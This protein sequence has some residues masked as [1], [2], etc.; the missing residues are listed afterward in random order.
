MKPTIL[1]VDDDN[2]VVKFYTR[3]LEEEGF[4]V[5]QTYDPDETLKLIEKEKP[6]LSAIILDIMMPPGET[7]SDEDTQ[8]GLRTGTFLY[9]DL[10]AYYPNVPVVVLTNVTDQET[11]R[12]FPNEPRL[13][14]ANKLDYTP[15]ELAELTTKMI[16]AASPKA[17]LSKKEDSSNE[18]HK[19]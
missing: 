17:T 2:L 12:Q 6:D 18:D 11:I 1:I 7:Y 5:R 14:I 8:E 3:A 9:N 15:F 16:E 10:K 4:K 19:P 13:R